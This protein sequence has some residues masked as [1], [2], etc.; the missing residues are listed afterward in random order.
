MMAWQAFRELKFAHVQAWST[1]QGQVIFTSK[2]SM[3]I[4]ELSLA[5]G[6]SRDTLRF[7]E[8]RGLLVASRR[9][10]G[11]RDYPP[12]AV[13]WLRYLSTAQ[14]LGFT[15]A[16]I[17]SGMP[18]FASADSSAPLL[19]D[20]LRRKLGDIDERIAGLAALRAE[21]ARRLD[22]PMQACPLQAERPD[23]D[24]SIMA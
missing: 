7:Y 10:N 18:L 24:S 9:G 2:E 13:D 21:L 22:A 19:R 3:Q 5:T 4:G 8:K 17:E 11:Y 12:E 15:L 16:E 1:L 6:L 20:A 14:T 23:R